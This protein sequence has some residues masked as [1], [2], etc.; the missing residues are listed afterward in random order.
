MHKSLNL[1]H[2]EQYRINDKKRKK[3]AINIIHVND[4]KLVFFKL[5]SY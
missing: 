1:M 4:F 2:V 3:H 5:A